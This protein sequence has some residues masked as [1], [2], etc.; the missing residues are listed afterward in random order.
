MNNIK[1]INISKYTHFGIS[2]KGVK[3]VGYWDD[4]IDDIKWIPISCIKNLS[5]S[6][7]VAIN[8]L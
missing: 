6:D 2:K 1:R 3:N 4:R 8:S 7:S 5:K